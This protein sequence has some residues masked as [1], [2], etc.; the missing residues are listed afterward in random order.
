MSVFLTWVLSYYGQL[1]CCFPTTIA[2][3]ACWRLLRLLLVDCADVCAKDGEDD[4][5]CKYIVGEVQTENFFHYYTIIL[6]S[7]KLECD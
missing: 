5:D 6:S 3:A 2:I 1:Q 7:S 4:Y